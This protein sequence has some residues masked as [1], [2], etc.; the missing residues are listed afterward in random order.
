[1]ALEF[2]ALA[3]AGGALVFAQGDAL[4]VDIVAIGVLGLVVSLIGI[5]ISQ[6]RGA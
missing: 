5:W 1:M 6:I 4:G 3:A 2:L